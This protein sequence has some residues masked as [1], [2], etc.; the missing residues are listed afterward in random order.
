[1]N[2]GGLGGKRKVQ[3]DERGE[4]CEGDR[5]EGR[6]EKREDKWK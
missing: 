2:E 3:G 1:M 5:D 4:L 6:G